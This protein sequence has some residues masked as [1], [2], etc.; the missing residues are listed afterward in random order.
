MNDEFKEL[1]MICEELR[2]K[3]VEFR[4]LKFKESYVS[5]VEVNELGDRWKMSYQDEGWVIE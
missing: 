3:I 4:Y 5:I 2:Y 1:L